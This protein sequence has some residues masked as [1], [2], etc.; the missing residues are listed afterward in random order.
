M[1]ADAL[2][3]IEFGEI[4]VWL[5]GRTTSSAAKRRALALGPCADLETAKEWLA[6]LGEAKRVV[7]AHGAWPSPSTEEL[8]EALESARRGQRLDAPVLLEVRRLLDAVERTRAYFRKLEDAPR[9]AARAQGLKPA[10]ELARALAQAIDP[11]GEILDGASPALARL[12]ARR[13]ETR[14][15][16]IERLERLAA[17]DKA[18]APEGE[19]FVTQR[20][21]RY[22]VPVRA[23]RF[24]RSKGVVHDVSRSGAVLFVEPFSVLTAN[25]ELREMEIAE[26]Q[27]VGRILD[28]L[29]AAVAESAD[30]LAQDETI[31]AD[32]DLLAA[33]VKLSRE[34]AGTTPRLVKGEEGRLRLIEARHPL[35]WRQSGGASDAEGARRRVVAFDLTLEGRARLLLVS[36]PNMGGKTVLLKA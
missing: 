18:N 32:L 11:Q 8:G 15:R 6:D 36:G 24:D 34:M 16:L 28:Q 30:V 20:D 2:D 25:N 29:T 31:L 26:A 17:R 4:R 12:R 9:A 7:E 22:V 35:L 14:A 33:R 3:R 13:K 1:G 19:G 10:G 5:A 23:D 27:E 21:G